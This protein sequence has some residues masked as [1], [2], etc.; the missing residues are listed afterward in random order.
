MPF[1]PCPNC[2]AQSPRLLESASKDAFVWYV[3][4]E[5]CGHVWSV[6]KDEHATV[7]DVTERRPPSSSKPADSDA[8][9]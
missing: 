5:D 1:R 8:D 6:S 9:Q 2:A 3:R 4:C 7:R